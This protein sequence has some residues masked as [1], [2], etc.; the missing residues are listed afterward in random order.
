VT[1]EPDATSV[2]AEPAVEAEPEPPVEAAPVVEA[3]P[4]VEE[5]PEPEPPV[6]PAPV[7]EEKPARP[8][9][10]PLNRPLNPEAPNAWR[11]W[12]Q[13]LDAARG[14]KPLN[15]IEQLFINAYVPL[16]DAKHRGIAG[17]ECGAVLEQ[18]A[19]SFSHSYSE[20]F[21]AMR[22]RGR[23]PMMVLDIVESTQRL[24]RLHGARNVQLILVD[25]MRFDLGVRVEQ[26]LV[27]ALGQ[28]A[29]LT[30]RFLLWSA[31][32]TTTAQQLELI[33][34]G[35]EGLREGDTHAE[36]PVL[37]ARGRQ[38]STLR[39]IRAGS[40]ELLKLDLVEARLSDAGPPVAQ[41]LDELAVEIADALSAAFT[42][43]APRTLVAVF[44]DHGFCLDATDQGSS[45]MR[46]GGSSPDEVLVPAYAWLVG[47]TH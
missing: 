40:R 8:P 42:R 9:L 45:A 41:R 44:G 31:L 2:V 26:H 24:A 32:P 47:Q 15:A 19:S 43:M 7:V 23:R 28:E 3:A 13:K 20:A 35:P 4:A 38:A 6:E 34:R 14:P 39:R 37:V 36:T 30:D 16:A 46:Q 29:T 27:G 5:K 1:T 11:H 18:W 33:G 25:G 10:V 22:L 17:P 21:D 12:M